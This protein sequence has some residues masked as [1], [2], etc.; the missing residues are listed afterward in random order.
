ME[1]HA[2][3]LMCYISV[4]HIPVSQKMKGSCATF[5]IEML[6]KIRTPAD[7]WQT[8]L[9]V[10]SDSGQKTVSQALTACFR[11]TL[12]RPTHTNTNRRAKHHTNS[13]DL[14][15]F[16]LLLLTSNHGNDSTRLFTQ[17]VSDPRQRVKSPLCRIEATS[18]G[19][20]HSKSEQLSSRGIVNPEDHEQ[21]SKVF[22][23]S[24][25]RTF[26]CVSLSGRARR[27][28]RLSKSVPFAF[29]DREWDA[30]T[31]DRAR[32]KWSRNTYCYHRLVPDT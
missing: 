25:E 31:H 17:R 8:R 6:L 19:H 21:V 1:L 9:K 26:R 23:A 29:D 13:N 28:R 11:L 30:T 24:S 3:L 20:R 22:I 16:D 12:F 4:S 18:N 15:S 10:P 14:T 27:N 7:T 32:S 5:T 2:W